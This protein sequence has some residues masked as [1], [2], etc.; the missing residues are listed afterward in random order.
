MHKFL[1]RAASGIIYAAVIVAA[2]LGGQWSIYALA[3]VFSSIGVCE[4]LHMSIGYS[5]RTL[6]IYIIQVLQVILFVTVIGLSL[7]LPIEWIGTLT[8]VFVLLLI[9]YYFFSRRILDVNLK[10]FLNSSM[11]KPIGYGVGY[12]GIPL[13]LMVLCPLP[14]LALLVFVL[15][16]INDSGAYIVGSL[17]GRHKLSPSISPNKTWEG[18]IGGCLLTVAGAVLL[19]NYCDDFFGLADLTLLTWIMIGVITCV[20]GT[21]GDLLESKIKRFYSVKDSG[22]WIPGHGGILDR[23]DSFLIAYPF[24][25]MMLLL[26]LL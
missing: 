20:F 6:P 12:L 18:F 2:I 13:A 24:V 10:K 7:Q 5:R 3:L 19:G 1:I 22:H 23:I 4:L 15:L 17:T 16:W 26:I 11:L 8:I 14:R 21:I 9:P 25:A